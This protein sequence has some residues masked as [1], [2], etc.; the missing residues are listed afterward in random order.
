MCNLQAFVFK[1]EG[2]LHLKRGVN[3]HPKT[4]GPEG[5][6]WCNSI[7]SL[8]SSLNGGGWSTPRSGHINPPEWTA[9]RFTEVRDGTMHVM[10]VC[11]KSRPNTGIRI[12][13][14]PACIEVLYRLSYQ[15]EIHFR[16]T[17]FSNSILSLTSSLNGAG[18]WSTTRP[19]HINPRNNQLSILQ[20]SG[21]TPGTL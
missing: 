4:E 8:T 19:G 21:M 15:G 10:E 12:P 7:L 18:G 13:Y 5:E 9:V 20:E 3:F 16:R 14:L 2:F 1:S 11:A 6:T 17:G